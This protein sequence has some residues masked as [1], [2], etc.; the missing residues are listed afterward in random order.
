MSDWIELE[1]GK[2]EKPAVECLKGVT[3]QVF[4]SPFDIPRAVRGRF[5][6]SIS[7]FAIEFEYIDSEPTVHTPRRVQ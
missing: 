4:M 2:F 6:Q 7:R 5:D 1:A 3:V